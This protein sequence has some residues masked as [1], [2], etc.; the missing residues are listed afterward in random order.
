MGLFTSLFG[1][2]DK[3]SLKAQQS[4]NAQRQQFI[5]QMYGQ[6]RSDI[7][8]MMPG[9]QNNLNMANQAALDVYGQAMPQQFDTFMQGNQNAQSALLGGIPQTYGIDYNTDFTQAQLPQWQQ[10]PTQEQMQMPQP[11]Q[12]A[13]GGQFG[14]F[15]PNSPLSGYKG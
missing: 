14:G 12:T 1:G 7:F 13:W 3:S 9:M 11:Q 2:T 15:D 6:G 4:D 5:E 10:A 8:N